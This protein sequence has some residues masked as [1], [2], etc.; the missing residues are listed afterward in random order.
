M[1]Q[2]PRLVIIESPFAARKPDGSWDP[3][4]VEEN[5][6]YV[7]AAMRCC[8]KQGEAPYASHALYTQPGVLDDQVPEERTLG[9]ESGFAWNSAARASIF[10][11]DRGI[12]SGMK[13]GI[14]NA[15]E[16]GR[17]IEVRSLTEFHTPQSEEHEEELKRLVGE[18][19]IEYAV[20]RRKQEEEWARDF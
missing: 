19:A 17:P 20:E 12:S 16:A 18:A 15:I 6:R 9:I 5:L 14:K 11:V 13:L 8:L 4:G 10:F 1:K 7:R 3:A 2:P